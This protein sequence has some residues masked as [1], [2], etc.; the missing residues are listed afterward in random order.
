MSWRTACTAQGSNAGEPR[1]CS[2]ASHCS[3]SRINSATRPSSRGGAAAVIR[4]S[5]RSPAA[6]SPRL[7]SQARPA[8]A[9]TRKASPLKTNFT[10][11]L[12]SP[13]GVDTN[14]AASAPWAT[15][16]TARANISAGELNSDSRSESFT[17]P[18]TGELPESGSEVAT[19][20]PISGGEKVSAMA[21]DGLA[22]SGGPRGEQ[23][24]RLLARKSSWRYLS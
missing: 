13:A 3:R 7:R 10:S 17:P 4:S 24:R 1:F 20:F 11:P 5:A 15:R 22:S 2:S 21:W 23:S 12:S 19:P 16:K 6:S 8:Q 9:T 14:P 18:W